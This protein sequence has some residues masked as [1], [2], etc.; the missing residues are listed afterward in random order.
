M[1]I[2]N[3]H[4]TIDL[5]KLFIE[6]LTINLF[7][8]CLKNNVV[9]LFGDRPGRYDHKQGENIGGDWIQIMPLIEFVNY[10]TIIRPNKVDD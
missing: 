2:M 8:S 5:I 1:I 4:N 6:L 10:R 9:A 7:R 3:L